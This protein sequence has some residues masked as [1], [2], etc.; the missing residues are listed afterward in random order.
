MRGGVERVDVCV[1]TAHPCCSVK[2]ACPEPT[3]R[4]LHKHVL[5]VSSGLPPQIGYCGNNAVPDLALCPAAAMFY[6]AAF[7]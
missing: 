7:T 5:N 6:Q 3:A 1:D 4:S 2:R